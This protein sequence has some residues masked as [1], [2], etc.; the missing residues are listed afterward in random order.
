M[1]AL[2]GRAGQIAGI[3]LN[4]RFSPPAG[5]RA[6][7][8]VEWDEREFVPLTSTCRKSSLCR[9]R[10]AGSFFPMKTCGSAS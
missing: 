2:V 3:S 5:G 10:L 6:R 7:A 8:M 1:G 9:R 4:L